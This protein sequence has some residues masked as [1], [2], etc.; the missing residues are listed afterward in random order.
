[1]WPGFFGPS[2]PAN[3]SSQTDWRKS[4]FDLAADSAKQLITVATG[5]IAA[6]G[7]FS[8]DL[9]GGAQW[10][11]LGSWLALTVSVLCGLSVLYNM[12][13]QMH[14]CA[15]ISKNPDLYEKGIKFFTKGQ[16]LLFVLG[17]FLIVGA[18]V[19]KSKN[20]PNDSPSITVNQYVPPPVQVPPVQNCPTDNGCKST[21]NC[22]CRPVKVPPP[23]E[24]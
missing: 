14:E 6:T 24:K 22:L 5:V 21:P 12:S 19:T 3:R 16:L 10:W 2:I 11:A 17:I 8:K 18:F 9:A 20:D 13:G 1:M 23:I 7:L 4:A 15:K